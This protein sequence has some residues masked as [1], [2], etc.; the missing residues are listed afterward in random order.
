MCVFVQIWKCVC[1]VP[2]EAR[3]GAS[4]PPKLEFQRV[5]SCQVGLGIKLGSSECS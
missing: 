3:R 5:V 4:R 2:A 1:V